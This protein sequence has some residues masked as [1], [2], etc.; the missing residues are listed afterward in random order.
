MKAV[1]FDL[2]GTLVNT[3]PQI[4]A[5]V[6]K[7][8][9]GY[10][11]APLP[12]AQVISF[13]GNGMPTLVRRALAASPGGA[14]IDPQ[15]AFVKLQEIY[16]QT[17]L[18]KLETFPGVR[19]VLS[20]LGQAGIKIGICTNRPEKLTEMLLKALDLDAYFSSVVGGDRLETCKPDPAPLALCFQEI[21]C[22][23]S[24]GMF[25]GDSE[26][27]EAT[28]LALGC[29]FALFTQGYR[30][31]DVGAFE[32][33]FAFDHYAELAQWFDKDARVSF[34]EQGD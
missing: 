19:D 9:H 22:D 18:D 34:V 8:L 6:N 31:K 33:I 25:V 13:V 15:T 27:D 14:Q 16:R 2:D 12:L 11:L 20:G 30:K 32:S 29:P 10:D 26:A 28:A 4:H 21:G 23:R 3:G 1:V 5:D 7:M 17:Q 24:E